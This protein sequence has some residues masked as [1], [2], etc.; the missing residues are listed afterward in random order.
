MCFYQLISKI[1][2]RLLSFVTSKNKIRN[3][4]QIGTNSIIN[5]AQMLQVGNNCSIGPNAV[6][7]CIYKKIILGNNVMVGPNVT[8]VNGDHNIKKIGIAMI[9]NHQ[10][11]DTDDAEIIIEDDVWIGAN[12]T[13]LK[14]VKIGRGAVIAAGAILS[15]SVLPYCIVGGINKVLNI[16][17][18]IEE[19]L[20]HEKILY[21]ESQRLHIED[22]NHITQFIENKKCLNQD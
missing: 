1:K 6:I 15:R 14:G 13:I 5:N 7:Y 10:K 18:Q 4:I 3:K 19:I 2:D 21:P 11:E 12:V 22:L 9:D 16:R 17:F 20:Q 8:M